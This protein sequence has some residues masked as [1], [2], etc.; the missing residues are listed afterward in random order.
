MYWLT[1]INFLILDWKKNTKIQ[2]FTIFKKS[3]YSFS[4]GNKVSFYD[5]PPIHVMCAWDATQLLN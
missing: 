5:H 2:C 3:A 1:E 4:K